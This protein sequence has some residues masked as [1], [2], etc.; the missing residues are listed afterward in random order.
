MPESVSGIQTAGLCTCKM[1]TIELAPL[2]RNKSTKSRAKCRGLRRVGQY[3]GPVED[4]AQHL[5]P[6]L[7]A[8]KTTGGPE[9]GRW[10][11]NVVERVDDAAH[12]K[13]DSLEDRA[14]DVRRAHVR[15]QAED[16]APRA[17]IPVGCPFA[18]EKR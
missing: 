10:S 9:R 11:R 15:R 17:C 5:E 8:G 18:G 6:E 3:H 16:N 4:V 12:A 1:P 13:A 14:R 2:H 7:G